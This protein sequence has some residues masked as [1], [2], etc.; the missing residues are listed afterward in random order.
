MNLKTILVSGKLVNFRG[1][2]AKSMSHQTQFNF[3]K[4][5]DVMNCAPWRQN[6]RFEVIRVT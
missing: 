6:H 4:R 3:M 5:L 2:G 1:I